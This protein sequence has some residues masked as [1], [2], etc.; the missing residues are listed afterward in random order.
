M[1]TC[2]RCG[3]QYDP[4]T[5]GASGPFHFYVQHLERSGE[6]M[7]RV[8][9]TWKSGMWNPHGSLFQK[10]GEHVEKGDQFKLLTDEGNEGSVLLM[11]PRHMA[12]L[13]AGHCLWS[14]N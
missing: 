3:K 9:V 13:V 12:N 7:V 4:S 6:G 14:S 11:D 2:D 8:A 1:A 5:R 10:V